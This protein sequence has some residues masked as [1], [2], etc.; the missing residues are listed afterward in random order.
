MSKHD[1]IASLLTKPCTLI[2]GVFHCV[3]SVP[4]SKSAG[5]GLAGGLQ[6]FLKK[7]PRLYRFLVDAFSPVLVSRAMRQGLDRALAENGPAMTVVNLGSGPL[8][9]PGRPDI[10]NVDITPFDCVD[11]CADAADIPFPDASVDCIFNLAMLE[12][13]PDP[14]AVLGEM[15]RVLRPGGRI[16]C[17]IPFCQPLHAA[18]SDYNRWTM[19]G[20]RELFRGFDSLEVAV[21]AGPTSGW[22]WTTVEWLSLLFSFGSAKA[23]DVLALGLML[24]LFPLKHLDRLLERRPGAERI[25]SGFFITGLKAG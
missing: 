21:G 2:D 19:N 3:E 16:C 20:A 17:F 12:H 11:I 13:V 10:I 24:A 22:L 4:A 5:G 18:P 23:R 9:L 6:G 25:A 7:W 8:G 1:T 15:R 14:H